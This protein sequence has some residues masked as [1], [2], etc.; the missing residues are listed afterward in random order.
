[1]PATHQ[2]ALPEQLGL[3]IAG[4]YSV[5]SLALSEAKESYLRERAIKRGNSK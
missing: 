3:G 4:S 2:T 5:K 1:M